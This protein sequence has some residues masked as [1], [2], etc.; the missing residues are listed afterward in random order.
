MSQ[1]LPAWLDWILHRT[2]LKWFLLPVAIGVIAGVGAIVF[3]LLS[4]FVSHFVLYR[5]TG[6]VAG[7]AA[8]EHFWFHFYADG[9][10]F[11]AWRL[12]AVLAC[13]GLL[14][15]CLVYF[16]APE[17]E[18]HGT[19]GAIEAFHHRRGVISPKV[20]F[21]KTLAS[22]VTLGTAGSGGREGPIAQIGATLGAWLGQYLTLPARDRRILLAAG[23]GAGVGAIFRSPLAGALFAGEIL[24]RSSDLESDAIVPSAIAS[25][26]AYSVYGLS[27]PAELCFGHVFGRL[28]NYSVSSLAELLP[29]AVLAAI[30]AFSSGLYIQI[31][32]GVHKLFSKLPGPRQIRPAIGAVLAGLVTM[33]VFKVTGD[34]RAWSLLST[35]YGTLQDALENPAA[36]SLSVG[37]LLTVGLLKALTTSLTISS[38]GSGGVFGPSMFIGG[39]VGAAVGLLVQ[40]HWMPGVNPGAFAVVGMAGFFSAGAKAPISTIV[41]V[42]EMTGNYQLLLPTMW[43]ST[44]CFLLGRKH[45]L[46]SKQVYSRLESPAHRGDFLVDVLEGVT[47]QDV[48]RNDRRI[49]CVPEAMPLEEI[50]HLISKSHQHYYPVVDHS[51]QMVGIFSS[52]DVRTYTYDDTIWQLADASDV[53]H[54]RFLFVHPKDDLNAAM[55]KFTALNIDELPVM[56]ADEDGKL[57]GMLRRKETIAA[58]NRELKKRKE[59]A[60]EQAR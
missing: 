52:D 33:F 2:E 37:I 9:L 40:R 19:D 20:A 29:Y 59:Q 4:Q 34:S 23:M 41:M 6:F 56:D 53:M 22:A 50:V 60:D 46:Y 25:I 32:Y 48:Y 13:G 39:C 1:R 10:E 51:G 7:E 43:V 38:G 18:G 36:P 31:F 54:S 14:S 58:Y 12:L 35:G 3:Q 57:L 47:V 42:T 26:V 27:L 55:R 49:E 21:I 44:L 30:L 28:P 45:N 16:F 24:Y 11:S 5:L 8:G 15:G 17:A